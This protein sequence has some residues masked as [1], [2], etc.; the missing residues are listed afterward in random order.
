MAT[1]VKKISERLRTERSVFNPSST[2]YKKT[3][4]C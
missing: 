3:N 1:D 2:L 4:V